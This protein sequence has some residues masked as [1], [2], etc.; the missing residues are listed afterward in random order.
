MNNII[1]KQIPELIPRHKWFR[2]RVFNILKSLEKV[3][4]IQDWDRYLSLT[5][6]LSKELDY[7]TLEWNKYYNDNQ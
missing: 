7:A 5:L 2:D 4:E 6:F 3:Q 1:E